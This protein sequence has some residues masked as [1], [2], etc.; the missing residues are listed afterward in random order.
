MNQIVTKFN[1]VLHH[2]VKNC[3]VEKYLHSYLEVTFSFFVSFVV[4][5]LLST[6][7][8]GQVYFEPIKDKHG[9]VVLVLMK[10]VSACASLEGLRWIPVSKFQL[11]RRSSSSSSDEPSALETLLTTLHVSAFKHSCPSLSHTAPF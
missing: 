3:R 2:L 11:Q 4:Q 9:N 5:A 6:V 10:D 7:D 1:N 8:L